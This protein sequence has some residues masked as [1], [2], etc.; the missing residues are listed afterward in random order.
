MNGCSR[1][2][3]PFEYATNVCTKY[4]YKVSGLSGIGMQL[5]PTSGG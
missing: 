2:E 5:S 1:L 3:T 4:A